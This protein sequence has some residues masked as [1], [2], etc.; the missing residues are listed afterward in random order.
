MGADIVT[1]ATT[2][3]VL[4]LFSRE[5]SGAWVER[6]QLSGFGF[7]AAFSG[8]T[9]VVGSPAEIID[10][11]SNA[12]AAYV[13]TTPDTTP[14]TVSIRSSASGTLTP[15]ATVDF[16]ATASDTG[17]SGMSKV[18]FYDGAV[19]ARVWDAEAY[20]GDPTTIEL[21]KV[22]SQGGAPW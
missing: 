19:T 16:T 2:A 22:E 7:V 4:A 15:P 11:M 20:G 9:L 6:E 14:P 8:Q 5:A 1:R 17:G 21:F 12:G 13:L 10:T 18:E 3:G